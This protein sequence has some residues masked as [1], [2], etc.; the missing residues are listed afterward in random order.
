MRRAIPLAVSVVL[1]A[2]LSACSGGSE[3]RFEQDNGLI[4]EI[5]E[6]GTGPEL[7]AG[8][9]AVMHYTG[10]LDAGRWAK[11]KKFDSS[12][13]RGT[14]FPVANVGNGPVIP[15]WN[16]GLVAKGDAPGMHVGEKR[17]LF[18]PAELAYGA[19]GAGTLIPPNANLIFDVELIEIR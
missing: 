7:S 2:C 10:W 4:V 8:Q 1:A 5:L 11:G 16:Q 9:T 12:L 18:I 13:D 19:T 3:A 14:P 6:P 17:R 15:G